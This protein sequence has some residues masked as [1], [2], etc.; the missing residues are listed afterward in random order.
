MSIR[1]ISEYC[2]P[3]QPSRVRACGLRRAFGFGDTKESILP[4]VRRLSQ[5]EP[6]GL[7]RGVSLAP[8][9]R[10]RTIT[11]VLAG[12]VNHGTAWETRELWGPVTCSG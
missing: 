6:R 4:P 5:R 2:S 8:A 1:P 10:D 3:S 12:T 7:P 11:Y 9:S